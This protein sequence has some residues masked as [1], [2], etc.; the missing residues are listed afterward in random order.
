MESDCLYSTP[1]VHNPFNQKWIL[2][3]PIGPAL[4]I[5]NCEKL[6]RHENEPTKKKLQI[7]FIQS[8]SSTKKKS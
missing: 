8:I 1:N 3:W 6:K 5:R 7:T 2:Y 4:T